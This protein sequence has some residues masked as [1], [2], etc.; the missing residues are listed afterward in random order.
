VIPGPK[1]LASRI[2]TT[3]TVIHAAEQ[4]RLHRFGIGGVETS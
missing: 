2:L 3:Q 1:R 4:A